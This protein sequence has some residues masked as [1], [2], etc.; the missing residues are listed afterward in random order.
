MKNIKTNPALKDLELLIGH[1]TTEL[2]NAS[3]LNDRS[4]VLQGNASFEWFGDG[5]F[6]V[7]YQGTKNVDAAWATWIIGRDQD[8]SDYTILYF[9]DRRF[10][11]VYEMSFKKGV[12]KIWRNSPK[13][14]QSFKGVISKDKKTITGR[15]RKSSDGKRWE[16]DFDLVYKRVST[17]KKLTSKK[18]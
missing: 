12:W 6:L 17:K 5:D 13:F 4:A 10:S 15:W 2:S 18:R 7:L 16:H 8:T 3:F 1:W 11:R 14:I 9:D